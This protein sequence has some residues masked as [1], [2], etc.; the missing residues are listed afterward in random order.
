MITAA[1]ICKKCKDGSRR[2]LREEAGVQMWRCEKCGDVLRW[3]PRCDQGWI[4]KATV[5]KKEKTVFVCEECEATWL[6]SPQRAPNSWQD[7]SQHLESIGV[8]PAWT[9]LEIIPEKE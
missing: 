1:P 7:M 8:S 9:E 5:R 2:L 6:A 4:S 3:C